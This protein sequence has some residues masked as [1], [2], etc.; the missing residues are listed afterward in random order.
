MSLN[1][2]SVLGL[3]AGGAAA[4][5]LGLRPASAFGVDAATLGVRVNATDD[6]TRALQGAIERTAG[7]RLPLVLPPGIYRTGEL[8]L[9][10]GTR[11]IGMNGASRLV[12]T[13]GAS[14]LTAVRGGPI[15][16]EGLAM[17]G[18][19]RPLPDGRGLVHLAAVNGLS[20]LDCEIAGVAGNAIALD[21]AT[22][23]VSRNTISG[24][25]QT[26]IFSLNAKGLTISGNTL[27]GIANNG[28]Q[29]W[30]ST[31]GDDG[32]LVIDN[33][34]EDTAARGGGSGQN[35]NAINVFRAANVM[36]RGNRVR[37]AAFSAVRGNAASNMQVLGNSMIGCGEVAIYAEFGFEGAVIAN[38]VI[39]G[40]AV[41]ASVTNFNV[42]GR[43]AV[44][45]GNLFRN[46]TAKRPPGTDP[47]DMAGLGISV[48]ADS[49]ISGNVI[50]TASTAGIWLGWGQY[51]RDIAVTGNVVRA[52]PV[53]IAV[54]VTRGA[55]QA[56][57]ADNLIA[58]ARDG[59]VVG[60]EWKKPV[61]GD[62]TVAGASEMAQVTVRGNRVR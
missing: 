29:V 8:K 7:A 58:G 43:L 5:A 37:G 21:G 48:E 36:V 3:G 32:T 56:L 53:G 11:I 26:G 41:G 18:A 31:A 6:Q 19:N 49:A 33:R 52:A 12:F 54:Q 35:G 2:R 34:I 16:L 14:M 15:A 40:A 24:V 30:R 13:Q 1:R 50:E 20:I 47:G 28:I 27:R 51:L 10:P 45:Q 57:I 62:L 46:I 17:E 4:L 23:E 61:T 44:V 38:N 9:P 42:G 55:G 25:S 39:D 22:G 60:M 59:A